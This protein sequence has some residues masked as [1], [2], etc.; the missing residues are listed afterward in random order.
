M[1]HR[2]VLTRGL[3]AGALGLLVAGAAPAQTLTGSSFHYQGGKPS[4]VASGKV[5]AVWNANDP[6]SMLSPGLKV[7][8]FGQADGCKDD[9]FNGPVVAKGNPRLAHAQEL[10]GLA[11]DPGD[12]LVW[13]PSGDSDQ[14][15]A[16]AHGKVGDSFVH[17]N[18]DPARGGIGL[19]SYTGRAAGGRAPFF[20]QYD[21]SGRKNTG[22]N[23]FINGTFVVFRFDWDQTQQIAPWSGGTGP[24]PTIEFRTVQSVARADV[25]ERLP[26]G[27]GNRPAQA[28]QQMVLALINRHCFAE[29]GGKDKLCQLKYLFNVAVFR[30]GVRSLQAEKWFQDAGVFLD[31]AQGGIPIVHGPLVA[32]G[33]AVYDK[34][35]RAPLYTSVGSPSRNEPFTDQRF[36][37]R[38]SFS[39]LKN[40]LRTIAS[41]R[42]KQPPERIGRESMV[43]HFGERWDDPKEWLVLSVNVSQ[44]VSNPYRLER[45]FIGGNVREIYAGP[46]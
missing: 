34:R 22:A 43:A 20:Q 18:T 39:Q 1:T 2:N 30:T 21:E 42:D 36:A 40:A 5:F 19:F 12:K 23:A 4:F 10:T 15:G 35:S 44:E 37:V 14:C 8:F 3:A 17:L 25:P 46:Q 28:K 24:D 33:A 9:A 29:G 45:A 11:L 27:G 32:A 13:S 31:P 16:D 6:K 7:T 38:V 41:V 26:P